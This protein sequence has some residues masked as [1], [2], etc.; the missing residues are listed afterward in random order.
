MSNVMSA[1]RTDIIAVRFQRI[2][3]LYHFGCAEFPELQAADHVIVETARG[4]QLGQVYALP[5]ACTE[6]LQVA[7]NDSLAA[8]AD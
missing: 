4:R 7:V 6:N 8:A 2:G 5:C 1:T 3:K